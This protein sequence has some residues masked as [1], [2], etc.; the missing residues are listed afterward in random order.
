MPT[1]A[2]TLKLR[3]FR[4]RF[5]ITAPRVVV[6]SH[7]PW[8]WLAPIVAL[9]IGLLLTLLWLASQ[10]NEVGAMG[11][12]LEELRQEVRGQQEELIVLRSTAGTGKSAVEMERAAQQE[13]LG[14]IQGLERENVALKED[15]LLFERLIPFAGEE[16]VVRVE[17]FRLAQDGPARYRYRLLVAF[18]PG[19]QGGDFRG[20]LQLAV[21]AV[22]GGKEYHVVLPEGRDAPA[23]YQLEVEHFLRREGVFSMPP[24]VLVKSVE[25]RILQGDAVRAK[26]MAQL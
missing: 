1:P 18:Q 2:V 9:V 25:A 20:R 22:K 5:G 26:R 16:T 4:R 24:D 10:R 7:W 12:E 21:N 15:M 6:R 8:R 13:L 17:N 11:R 19:K 3:R 23:E 14:K